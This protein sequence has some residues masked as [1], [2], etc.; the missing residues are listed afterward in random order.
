MSGLRRRNLAALI[1]FELTKSQSPVQRLQLVPHI[2]YQFLLPRIAEQSKRQV[3]RQLV[4][5]YGL[6]HGNLGPV[7]PFLALN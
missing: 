3:S 2:E 6:F 1:A 4:S 7:S 5:G